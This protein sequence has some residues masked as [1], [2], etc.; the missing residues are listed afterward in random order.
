M[1]FYGVVQ[2]SVFVRE[3][4]EGV[5]GLVCFL[6]SRF[7]SWHWCIAIKS[8]CLVTCSH[9]AQMMTDRQNSDTCTSPWIIINRLKVPQPS[10]LGCYPLFRGFWVPPLP[11]YRQSL[12]VLSLW[13]F[14][15]LTSKL[16]RTELL[17]RPIEP[18]KTVTSDKLITIF[19]R[20]F[21][22]FR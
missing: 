21:S 22:H 1:A 8:A 15:S 17:H 16:F 12:G 13:K 14:P 18:Q 7:A 20:L 19:E 10:G 2:S 3:D 9:F 4:C 6:G 11:V 5:L